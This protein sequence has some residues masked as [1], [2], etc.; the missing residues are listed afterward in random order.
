MNGS[1]PDVN[2][3]NL[4][5]K[6]FCSFKYESIIENR[7]NGSKSNEKSNE[8][9]NIRNNKNLNNIT[10]TDNTN[11]DNDL[12]MNFLESLEESYKVNNETDSEYESANEDDSL[13]I[14]ALNEQNNFFEEKNIRSEPIN[15]NQKRIECS[16][17]EFKCL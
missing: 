10:D 17:F 16:E 5:E 14:N 6:Q 7:D 15:I 2:N 9:V 4:N 12:E 8:K 1:L 11:Q 3:Y 13:I